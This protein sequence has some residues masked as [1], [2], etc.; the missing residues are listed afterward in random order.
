[1]YFDIRK[2]DNKMM[3]NKKKKILYGVITAL[4][5]F[6][7][8]C[9]ISEWYHGKLVF[10]D[11]GSNNK[12][13]LATEDLNLISKDFNMLENGS[14]VSTSP[15]PWFDVATHYPVRTIV[16]DLEEISDKRNAQIFFSSDGQESLSKYFVLREGINYIQIP[17]G[18]YTN[19]RLDLVENTGIKIKINSITLYGSRVFSSLFVMLTVVLWGVSSI[20]LY[21]YMFRK[22]KL[23]RSWNQLQY[24]LGSYRFCRLCLCCGILLTVFC[25]Y[26]RILVS[27]HEYIYYDIGGGDGPESS[28]PAFVSYV[29]KIRTG[30]LSAWNFDNG[31]GTSTTAFWGYLLNPYT[32][33][34]FI[35]ASIFGISAI[36][37]M[38]LVIQICNIFICGLL[39]YKYLSN[40]KGK[41][42][43][44]AMASYIFSFNGY[45]ILW[46][47]HYEFAQFCFCLLIML[48]IIEN[49]LKSQ[50]VGKQYFYFSLWCAVLFC[51]S[52]YIAYM[53]SLFSGIYV[54][55][56]MIQ[57]NEKFDCKVMV[58]RIGI[59]FCFAVTGLMI[60]MPIVLPVVYGM[61]LNSDRITGSEMGLFEKIISFLTTPYPKEAVRTF[62]LRM[63]SNNLEGA[64]NDFWGDCGR[65]FSDYYSA[66]PLY[67]SIFFLTFVLVYYVTLFRREKRKLQYGLQVIVGLIVSFVIFNRLGSATFNAFVGNF[68]RYT[69]LLMPLFAIMT[70][71][72]LDEIEF[73]NRKSKYI[74]ISSLIVPLII[75]L[76]HCNIVFAREIPVYL[77]RFLVIEILVLVMAIVIF[78]FGGKIKGSFVN[79]LFLILIFTNII[80]DSFVTV[81]NRVF[82]IFSEDLTD[83]DDYDTLDALSNVKAM[84]SSMY[85]LEKN[86]YDLIYFN[87]ARFQNYRGMSTY[88]STLNANVKE[89]YRLYCNPAVNFY[90]ENSFWYSYMNI[91]NDVL[92]SSL[93][94]IRYILSNGK[95]Y[96][97]GIYD[98]VYENK[99]VSVY[100]NNASKSFGLFYINGIKKSEV[101][102]LDYVNRMKALS[103]AIV[104]EDED[105]ENCIN[106][107]SYEE[108]QENL[109]EKNIINIHTGMDMLPNDQSSYQVIGDDIVINA[110]EHACVDIIFNNDIQ[111]P[112]ETAYLEFST[113]L[114]YTDNLM[115]YFDTGDGFE[116]LVPYYY[117]GNSGDD[118]QEARILLPKE[119]KQIRM[120]CSAADV[121][122]RDFRVVSSE[123][124]I[125][126]DN[127][128]IYVESSRDSRL[129]GTVYN[130]DQGYLFLPIPYEKGW[131]AYVDGE[132]V[133]IIQADSAFMALQLSPGKH[134][135]LL[136]YNYPGIYLGLGIGGIGTGLF[137]ICFIFV[138]RERIKE[139]Y[140]VSKWGG[141]SG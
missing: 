13:V 100:R 30:T 54:I 47:Q 118:W 44:K 40:F 69:Y 75:V 6:I 25:V 67:F 8:F 7:S 114:A 91:S 43:S 66:P 84:D 87:D 82:C 77:E 61:L 140:S 137:M 15:D 93:M 49:M 55:F 129:S 127:A 109:N 94:G 98:L 85:R 89:F 39:C 31:L 48:I 35:A 123:N 111:V 141:S 71:K 125:V 22:E 133:S 116:A 95:A 28:I 88:N 2:K 52:V 57:I 130:E 26:G 72:V 102:G 128:V 63:I 79:K 1:M 70:V 86:Y 113:D 60:A 131:S 76:I 3:E 108:I 112:N 68:E 134:S 97:N 126:P 78:S 5:L 42:S 37:T 4:L 110:D 41:D 18:A 107:I 12:T 121:V 81:N 106:L 103:N 20:I 11:F 56:R 38:V 19:F 119:T 45:M 29:N 9:V 36:N 51:E 90:G 50:K 46:A 104:V 73:L 105:T 101:L 136:K 135:F 59:M 92:Q 14:F 139:K 21:M 120:F 24:K 16:I 34:I 115:I 58:R 27:G 122:I 32:L 17:K 83:E 10:W 65:S 33:L 124:P 117:R 53:I 99:K 23:E 138:F 96:Q 62:I 132:K 64:G 80:T 74:W